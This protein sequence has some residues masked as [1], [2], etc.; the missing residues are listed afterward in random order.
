MITHARKVCINAENEIV[1]L[2]TFF[3]AL[4][5]P[6]SDVTSRGQLASQKDPS[7]LPASTWLSD[8][9]SKLKKKINKFSYFFIFKFR[10]LGR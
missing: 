5:G 9:I 2:T 4:C 1:R 8:L 3:K 6:H 7:M 10:A